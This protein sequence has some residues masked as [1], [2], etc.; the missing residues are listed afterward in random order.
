[1]KKVFRTFFRQHVSDL[2]HRRSRTGNGFSAVSFRKSDKNPIWH[3]LSN[4]VGLFLELPTRGISELRRLG[5]G[6]ARASDPC[7]FWRKTERILRNK[8][9][10]TNSAD[11]SAGFALSVYFIEEMG[12]LFTSLLSIFEFGFYG[13][14]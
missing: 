5:A 7:E 9:V 8:L 11:G 2:H 13:R 10:W 4:W 6:D 12:D 3:W 14:D 1:M